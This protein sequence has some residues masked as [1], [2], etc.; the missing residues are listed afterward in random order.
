MKEVQEFNHDNRKEERCF[1]WYTEGS[2]RKHKTLNKQ[3]IAKK[4]V[5]L[6]DAQRYI[7]FKRMYK[8]CECY[9]KTIDK[10]EKK[11]K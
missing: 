6:G 7:E 4:I 5:W 8:R 11:N 10:W 9:R 3:I 1:E 2:V